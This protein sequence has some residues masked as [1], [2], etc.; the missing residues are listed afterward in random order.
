MEN[1]IKES[2]EKFFKRGFGELNKREKS[3]IES[4]VERR[5]ISRDV[6][7][8]FDRSMTFG[9]RIADK[10]AAF[11]GSWTFIL[12]FLGVLAAWIVWNSYFFFK[13]AEAFDP[14]PYILLN[15]VLSTLAAIQAPVIL[16]SQNRQSDR[17][18]I[19]AAH[20]F[21]VN[22]KAEIEILALHEKVD[23]LRE[24]KWGELIET[25]RRQIE[26]LNKLLAEAERKT[27]GDGQ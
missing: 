15:L 4:V 6:S 2:L 27:L 10:V 5:Q 24:Q 22:L 3:I 11:G 19:D 25:Q 13:T 17:D 21:E 18:R 9:Q 7:S 26:I 23:D 12:L 16:M 14:F 8:D 20:D 1:R